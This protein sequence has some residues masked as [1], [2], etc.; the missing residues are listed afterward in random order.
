MVKILITRPKMVNDNPTSCTYRWG[1]YIIKSAKSFGHEVIDY[2]S[3]AVTYR[4]VNEALS[5]YDPDVYIHLG[6]GCPSNLVGQE[7]C[8]LTNNKNADYYDD[9]EF[10]DLYCSPSCGLESNVNMLK[11]KIVIAYA[12]HSSK[13]LGEC[14]MKFG[15]K[16]YIGFDDY[17]IFM[18]DS[19]NS[20]SLFTE[21]LFEFTDSLF[22]GE[23]LAL[24]KFKADILYDKN[25]I[26][27]KDVGYLAMLLLWD[28]VS[29][30][31]RGDPNLTIFN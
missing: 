27:Y 20:E 3:K 18:T 19:K 15:A 1:S 24:A 11:D 23:N 8:I 31:V 9:V 17:L 7:S 4:K 5:Y 6:H 2:K 12:C 28:K 26:K 30:N 13:R 16:A 14:A 21:P 25:I 10:E 22:K 29:F